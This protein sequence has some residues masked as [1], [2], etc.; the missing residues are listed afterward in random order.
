M[1]TSLR[2]LS[3]ALQYAKGMREYRAREWNT[4]KTHFA[5]ALQFRPDFAAAQFKIG[6]CHFRQE[7]WQEAFD[8]MQAAIELDPSKTQWKVQR[9]Q[10][11]SYLESVAPTSPA[12]EEALLQARIAAG[13]STAQTHAKLADNFRR[14][15]RS[16]QEIEALQKAID[17]EPENVDILFKLGDALDRMRRY[18]Q[19]A[20]VFS[21]ASAL[22]PANATYAYRAGFAY[23]RDGFDGP[24]DLGKAK[25]AYGRAIATD[26]SGM[27]SK[28]GIGNFH[29]SRGLWPF[30]A[31]AYEQQLK[32]DP[33][34]AE[35]LYRLGLAYDRQ[36]LWEKAEKFISRS[37]ILDSARPNRLTRLGF[38]L[39]RQEKFLE[40]AK[41]YGA[42]AE[43]NNKQSSDRRYRQGYTLT[44]AG[45]FADGCDAFAKMYDDALSPPEDRQD[46]QQ[47]DYAVK[48]AQQ[49]VAELTRILSSDATSPDHYFALGKA[50]EVLGEWQSAADCYRSAIARR[51]THN[52]DWYYRLGMSLIKAER[53]EDACRAFVETR[54]LTTADGWISK[55][56]LKNPASFRRACYAEYYERLPIKEKT[57]LYESFHGQPMGCNPR[58]I[59]QHLLSR[60][61]FSDWTHI[62][63][64]NDRTA[65][66]PEFRALKNLVILSR[67]SDAYMRAMAS[68]KFLVNNTTFPPEFVRKDGQ[69]YLNTW[70]GTPIKTLGKF[71]AGSI[72]NYANTTRNFLQ[73]THLLSPNHYTTVVLL[74]HYD[75]AG[76]YR[77]EVAETGYPRMDTTINMDDSSRELLRER[78]GAKPGQKILL[79]APT[80][81]GTFGTA[82]FDHSQL[83]AD[84]DAMKHEDYLLLFRGHHATEK[85]IGS[86]PINFSVVDKSIDSNSLLSV[87]D[88]LVSDY[89]SIAI[90]FLPKRKPI[91]YYAY[92]YEEYQNERGLYLNLEELPG[93]VVQTREAL[94]DAIANAEERFDEPG[95]SAA[96]ERFCPWDDGNVTKRVVDWA[97]QNKEE[98]IRLVSVPK[99]IDIIFYPGALIPNGIATSF[100]N[101]ASQIDYSKYTAACIV[102]ANISTHEDRLEQLRRLP[103]EMK[104]IPRIGALLFTPEEHW[105]ESKLN[106]LRDASEAMLN[107]LQHAYARELRRLLGPI[108]AKAMINF[109]GYTRLYQRLFAFA[110]DD[111]ADRRILF[112][113]ND[114]L[115]EWREK[116]P[117]LEGLFRL[118]HKYDALVSVSETLKEINADSLA[119]DFRIPK[120]NFSF[121]ENMHNPNFVKSCAE[122]DVFSADER[123][124]FDSASV[125]F[126]TMGR[127]SPEKD[128]AKLIR[129]FRTLCNDVPKAKLFHLGDGPLRSDLTN[130][131][132]SLN[133][134]ENVHLLGQKTNPFPYLLNADCFVLPSNHEGQPMVLIEALIL[135]RPII[136]T[137][138]PGNRGA[139]AGRPATLVENNEMALAAAMLEFAKNPS[140]DIQFDINAYQHSALAQFHA[141]LDAE[142]SRGG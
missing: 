9:D 25:E 57:V 55:Q 28:F 14:Q 96:I 59:F 51:D 132:R 72:A 98:C 16:W 129:A 50:Y 83:I 23:E 116:H 29:Q 49:S 17:L 140:R 106:N 15:G 100:I 113:H 87:V 64:V 74:E 135:N 61:E 30:A 33:N 70:H 43:F 114:M 134:S 36:F 67:E 103:S 69:V 66:A 85:T 60:E 79:Y 93:Q 5:N 37:V 1:N 89:S 38:V 19:S 104:V 21:R 88:L 41:A 65:V 82:D 133:L 31:A 44:Q 27:S 20:D 73:A 97:F 18:K 76:V 54:C 136:A 138:I 7:E 71:I 45:A 75:I 77:G 68:A 130:L 47:S 139:L 105:V 4:S 108:Q 112:L 2:F 26:K 39:E 101:L 8:A 35:L 63:V 125:N 62:W 107:V 84:L 40:A 117:Y 81:R 80:F 86:L 34:N 111:A 91:I 94:V 115:G 22:R 52:P 142:T 32:R 11:L 128:Q 131:V 119:G 123:R 12:R 48:L 46:P 102:D 109:E 141:L 118:Y 110:P 13:D 124:L 95:H 137:D 121:A 56:N 58:A 99:S 42:A 6:M 10:S 126:L 92:D 3:A 24:P 127:M 90:D 122:L 53:L 78:L 120:V